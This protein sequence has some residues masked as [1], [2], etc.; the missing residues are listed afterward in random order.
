MAQVLYIVSSSPF[1]GK[2]LVS[3]GC[4]RKMESDKLSVGIFKPIGVYPFEHEGSVGDEDAM[5]FK[6]LLLLKEPIGDIC[7]VVMTEALIED[8]LAGEI[9]KLTK[10]VDEAYKKVAHDKD[11]VI[12]PGIGDLSAGS[13]FGLSE[14]DLIDKYGAGVIMV[15]RLDKHLNESLDSILFAKKSLGNKLLGVVL[16]RVPQDRVR[17][18]H[19]RIRPF[20]ASR[21]MDLIGIVPED[22]VL[23]AVSIK[24]IRD[25]LHGEL[26]IGRDKQSDLIETYQI[27]AMQVESALSHFRRVKNK[28]VVIGGDRQD[29][30]LAAME[31]DTKLLIL[32]GGKYPSDIILSRGNAQGIAI[33]VSK[34]DTKT[35]AHKLEALLNYMSLRNENKARQ[36]QTVISK[37]INF[38]LLYD[39]LGFKVV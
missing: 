7:P 38:S 33:L 37:S 17:W 9:K 20:L 18:V 21:G 16:N 34:E 13:M 12:V 35:T 8:V 14:L 19:D 31:T 15:G 11:V 22:S 1:S 10:K 4:Y 25:T 32:T 27:G 36:A 39:K 28:A 3:L 30:Q 2:N 5:F 26:V 23:N 24:E 6:K 29:V